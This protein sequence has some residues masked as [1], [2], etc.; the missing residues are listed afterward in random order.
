MT[1]AVH[2]AH[3]DADGKVVSWG[4]S[5]G[6]DVFLQSLRPGLTAVSRPEI[7]THLSGHEYRDG[8]WIEAGNQ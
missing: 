2:W 8:Q 3:V 6:S 5:H 1:N 7:V 4:T